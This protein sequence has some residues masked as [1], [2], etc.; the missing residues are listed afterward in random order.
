MRGMPLPIYGDGSNLRSYL[1][2]EDVAEAFDVVVLHRGDQVG[3]VYNIAAAKGRGVVDVARDICGILGVDAEKVIRFMEDRPFNDQRYFL[4]GEKM[5]RLGYVFTSHPGV[6]CVFYYM[7][8]DCR[9]H[10]KRT[11]RSSKCASS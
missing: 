1:H 4:D 5:R 11:T 6:S 3:H 2:C 7:T 9:T 10:T 8:I